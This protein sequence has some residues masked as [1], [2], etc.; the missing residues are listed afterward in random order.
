MKAHV[1]NGIYTICLILFSCDGELARENVLVTGVPT[2][3]TSSSAIVNGLII[4]LVASVNEHGHCWALSPN[5]SLENN[6]GI[7]RLGATNERGEFLSVLQNL[8]PEQRYFVAAYAIQDGEVFYGAVNEFTTLPTSADPAKALLTGGAFNISTHSAQIK[9]SI[10]ITL[11]TIVSFGHCWS[12]RA[13]PSLSD[14][15]TEFTDLGLLQEFTSQLEELSPA[16]RYQ[17]CAYF[18]TSEGN[19]T[20]GAISSFQTASQ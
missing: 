3:I 17:V 16:T 1:K 9:G 5:P 20:Y 13:V 6:I 15:F 12:E 18:T 7:T 11:N 10:N 4:D 2:N 8:S 14:N 19:T